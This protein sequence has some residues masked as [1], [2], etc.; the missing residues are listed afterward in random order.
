VLQI[1]VEDYV[2][3]EDLTAAFD[4]AGLGA[5]VHRRPGARPWPT[6]R[7]MIAT[8]QRIVVL[9]EKNAGAQP[10]YAPTYSG[11]VQETP[12]SWSKP[13]LLTR[14]RNWRAS[15]RAN[16]GGS[17]GSLFL[18]NH[19][20]PPFAPKAATA[21]QVN[22]RRAVVGRALACR[23]RRGRMPTMVA[24]DMVDVGSLIQAVRQLNRRRV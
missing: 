17:R 8:S 2:T 12:Y 9:A 11:I 13:S 1:I 21:A 20:S 10:W 23:K 5:L 16:R 6:L 19:W 3:P 14:K 7:Q 4:A 18:M 22:S 15:C 24:A